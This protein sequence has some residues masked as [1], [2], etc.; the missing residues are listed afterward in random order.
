MQYKKKKA[1]SH[2]DE[3]QQATLTLE[4]PKTAVSEA[5]SNHPN[6]VVVITIK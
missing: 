2:D 6:T 4:T 3:Y 1:D 5:Y